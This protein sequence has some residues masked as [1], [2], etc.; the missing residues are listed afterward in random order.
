MTSNSGPYRLTVGGEIDRTRR[1]EF[2]F[3]G[4]TYQG[5]PGDT[6]ASALLAN[7]VRI[8]A[9]S[10]KFHR[11]RGI[12]SCGLEEP[13]ALV[14]L[15][16]GARVI[17][18]SRAPAV[19][20][21]EGLIAESQE[22]WPS[23][24]FDVGRALDFTSC[25]WAAGF[26]NKTFI[27]PNWH[28]YEG[29]IR[30][31]AGLGR[32]PRERDPDRY[33]VVNHH[34]DVLV[35]GGGRAGLCAALD[36]ARAGASVLLAE[37]GR[38]LGGQ[39][40]WDRSRIGGSSAEEWVREVSAD[41]ARLPRVRLLTRTAAVGCY[42]HNAVALAEQREGGAPGIPRERLHIVRAGRIVLATG[43]IEQPLIFSNN[44]RP[45]IVLAGAARQYLK[46]YGIA[47]G[48]RVVIATNNDSAYSLA[49][50]L[51]D[52]GVT[53]PAVLDSRPE[54][55][56]PEMLRRSLRD[57]GIDWLSQSLPIDTAGFAHLKS[58]T[59][60]RLSADA[61]SIGT[62]ETHPCDALAVSGG[63]SPALQLYAQAGGKLSFDETSGTLHPI[64]R[65]LE[66][67]VEA[68]SIEI[69]G[70]AAQSVRVGPRVS[71]AGNPRRQWVDLAH[72]VTVSDLQ[73]ALRESYS[74]I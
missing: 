29:L 47:I 24:K 35:V 49:T 19:D 43:T 38:A 51:K 20:L 69:V 63:F 33:E 64:A 10:F 30:R 57:R 31:L 2:Q 7:G 5:H 65:T 21:H 73:L 74:S 12:F 53:V 8:V 17:P 4:R 45:G 67:S 55:T 27:W 48:H 32:A 41:L 26:Y 70:S 28:T 50:E 61:G 58:V 1:I 59:A 60:G 42:D 14:Q 71:P 6:L 16:E 15:G 18:S 22:G 66:T 3:D 13:N 34:C 68:R 62:Q 40:A 11:P 36:P 39:V 52:A 56:V 25:L 54:G 72:D 23:V 37:Q 46:R 9:R 44:D